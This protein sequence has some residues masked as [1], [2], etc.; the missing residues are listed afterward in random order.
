MDISW[1]KLSVCSLLGMEPPVTH[2]VKGQILHQPQPTGSPAKRCV[3][4]V[5][6][7]GPKTSYN[8]GYGEPISRVK[9]PQG[10]PLIFGHL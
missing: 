5:L 2:R 10:N 1:L 3:Y 4:A 8:W 9:Y 7:V 6:M